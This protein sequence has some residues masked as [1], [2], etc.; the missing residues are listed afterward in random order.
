[1]RRTTRWRA[2]LFFSSFPTYPRSAIEK[3]ETATIEKI[4]LALMLQDIASVR[5]Y[6]LASK[7][8][9]KLFKFSREFAPKLLIVD[10][11]KK[12]KKVVKKVTKPRIILKFPPFQLRT[13]KNF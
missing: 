12:R 10:Y 3:S 2:N 5:V 4:Y 1:L 9:R 6:Q 13:L 8:V 7:D 11:R